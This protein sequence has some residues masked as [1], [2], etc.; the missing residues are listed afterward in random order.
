MTDKPFLNIENIRV[1]YQ[2]D[3]AAV[4]DFSLQLNKGELACLVGPS[5]CGKTTV[6]RAISGFQA[7]EKGQ[8]DLEQQTLCSASYSLSPE[9]R[10][11]G[12]VF[13]EHAL[14]PHLTVSENVGFGL[15]QLSAS[16]RKERVDDLLS[17]VGL[18]NFSKQYPHELSG[19]Q[20]QRV[21]LA[22]AL[23]PRPKLL[24]LDEPFSSLDRHLRESLGL[25]VR[26]LLK[27][28]DMTAVLVSHDQN[29]AFAL[30]DR[31]GVMNQG[32]LEQW[33]TPLAMCKQPKSAFVA[34]FIG[35]G[36][37]LPAQRQSTNQIK[38]AIG[39]HKVANMVLDHKDFDDKI[40]DN[41]SSDANKEHTDLHALIKPSD[42][43]VGLPSETTGTL[44][45]QSH[46][47][48]RLELLLELR[49]GERLF[50]ASDNTG[51]D[52]KIGDQLPLRVEDTEVYVFGAD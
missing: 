12:M 20:S 38:T 13:Q 42:V 30:A 16:K 11:V 23:A 33:A 1:S 51:A 21:A 34:E 50:V 4:S 17:L 32:S 31:V 9:K 27:Q 46:K 48:G 7:L 24:L 44:L 45:R 15:K 25:E 28:L 5:G 39:V 10:M 6:L 47:V 3:S 26:D 43:Q 41:K 40:S 37:V 29:E 14:F 19:G 52:F 22:R 49:T 2:D 36:K 18:S 35:L 8:I